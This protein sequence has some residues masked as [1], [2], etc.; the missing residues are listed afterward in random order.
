MAHVRRL[1]VRAALT[2][3]IVAA[4]LCAFSQPANDK[5]PYIIVDI[6]SGLVIADRQAEQLWYPASLTKLMTA[7]VTFRAIAAGKVKPTTTIVQTA[8]A[9][10]QAPAKMGFDVGARIRLDNALKMMIV[11][12]ANDIAVAIAEGVAR[13]VPAFVTT[14]NA[15]AIRLGMGKTHFENPTGLP[16][17]AQ[18]STA[19]DLAILARQIWIDFPQHRSLFGI[20]AISTSGS[21][22][23][24]PNLLLLERYAGAQGMQA[25]FTCSAGYNVALTATR[26][27]RT[28]LA[29]VLGRTSSV[30]RSELAARLLN[31][32]FTGKTVPDGAINLATFNDPTSTSGPIDLGICRGSGLDRVSFTN[33]RLGRATAVVS[34]MKV[35]ADWVP[36]KPKPPPTPG[37]DVDV[38]YIPPVLTE[39]PEQRR[40]RINNEEN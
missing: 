33:S 30:D 4:P 28:L 25:G 22:F 12:S 26:N 15:E 35:E 8:T 1:I 29:V 34:P 16:V 32:A 39:L 17:E 5:T 2:I 37:I 21:V 18:V 10:A 3:A 19:R 36:P 7:Y 27:G 38:P 6:A 20:Q 11:P 24:S 13:S 23:H 40:Y 31:E 9:V 14:M